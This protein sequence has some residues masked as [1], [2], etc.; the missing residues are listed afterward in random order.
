MSDFI[1]DLLELSDA[2]SEITESH[3]QGNVKKVTIRKNIR[4]LHCH[5]ADADCIPKVSSSAIPTTRSSKAVMS[6]RS[7]SSEGDGSVPIPSVHTKKLTSLDSSNV[8]STIQH[9]M[10]YLSFMN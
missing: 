3:I 5:Y 8:T 10:I 7:P 4:E 1:T 6:L 2:D 9:S